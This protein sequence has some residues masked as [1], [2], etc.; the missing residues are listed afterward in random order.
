MGR[1]RPGRIEK[2]RERTRVLLIVDF[3]FPFAQFSDTASVPTKESETSSDSTGAPKVC[4]WC[5]KVLDLDDQ[6]VCVCVC[7]CVQSE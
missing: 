1:I 2:R 3:H 4:C 6:A 7:V 5:C